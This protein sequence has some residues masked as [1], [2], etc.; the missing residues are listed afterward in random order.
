MFYELALDWFSIIQYWQPMV[1]GIEKGREFEKLLQR[2]S[3][4]RHYA[5]S[6]KSG[7]RTI[8]GQ[9]SASGFMHEND[10]VIKF[11]ELTI[12]FEMK[13]LTTELGK[14]DLLIFN[15][16]GLDYLAGDNRSLR[17][18][19]FY[20]IL[21]SGHRVSAAAR[22]FALQWGILVIEPDRLPLLTL[23]ELAGYTIPNL[24]FLSVEIHNEIWEE[25]PHLVVPLQTRVRQMAQ[26][27]DQDGEIIGSH[28]IDRMINYLQKEVGDEYWMALD[29]LD[30]PN[31][32]EE[33]FELL[34]PE[35]D[36]A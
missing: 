23:H 36:L 17:S 21:L 18:R 5:L 34:E 33:R 20:R 25:V 8:R 30:R 6:E 10:A 35:L 26:L 12:H 32:L 14:N 3:A 27:L 29:D 11:P 22:R 19:P 4:Y 16:K 13:H 9:Q 1:S 7:S 28:R 31:W 2:Y 15:Q 24:D